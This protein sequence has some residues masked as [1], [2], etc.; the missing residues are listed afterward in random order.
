MDY[1]LQFFCLKRLKTG[2]SC[3]QRNTVKEKQ[4]IVLFINLPVVRDKCLAH[5][6]STFD[7]LL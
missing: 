1:F 3:L 7:E 6:V 5:I 2:N 4:I